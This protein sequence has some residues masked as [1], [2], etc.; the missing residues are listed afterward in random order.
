MDV[1]TYKVRLTIHEMAG[2]FPGH[3]DRA[4]ALLQHPALAKR[5]PAGI[6]SEIMEDVEASIDYG[7]NGAVGEYRTGFRTA[8]D[9]TYLLAGNQIKA[10]LQQSAQALYDKAVAGSPSVHKIRRTIKLCVS[11][12]PW[13]IPLTVTGE[14]YEK[15]ITQIVNPEVFPPRGPVPIER[16]RVILPKAECAFEVAV[17]DGQL[18]KALTKEVLRDLF[19]AGAMFTGLGTDRGY[20]H[21][22]F[23]AEVV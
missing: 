21:G 5:V 1:K 16:T 11:V 13:E 12:R 2:G 15:R 4:T 10:M 9:G 23:E 17:L 20:N 3:I 8:K 18:G 19:D 22:R 6:R 14:P 7:A